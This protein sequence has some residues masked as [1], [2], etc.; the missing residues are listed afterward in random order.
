MCLFFGTV[1]SYQQFV[2]AQATL[3]IKECLYNF[4]FAASFVTDGINFFYM[5]Y[6]KAF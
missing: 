5:E 2:K 4:I 1:I 3:L 6:I